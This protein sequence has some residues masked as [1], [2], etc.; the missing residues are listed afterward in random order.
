MFQ[1]S[2]INR[3]AITDKLSHASP[4]LQC[5]RF[6]MLKGLSK[7]RYICKIYCTLG[8]SKMHGI[9]PRFMLGY[10]KHGRSLAETRLPISSR[11]QRKGRRKRV[12]GG[13]RTPNKALN[14]TAT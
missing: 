9:G 12:M 3:L 5:F 13:T 14:A 6:L 8:L 1:T 11:G 10:S 4:E 7:H 2:W